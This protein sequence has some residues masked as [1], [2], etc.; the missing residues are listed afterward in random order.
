M[1][2]LTTVNFVDDAC[3]VTLS[4]YPHRASLK[5]LPGH[6][7]NCLFRVVFVF[8]EILFEIDFFCMK[9]C[10]VNKI[11]HFPKRK[12]ILWILR[13][14]WFDFLCILSFKGD[15]IQGNLEALTCSVRSGV[16]LSTTILNVV[17]QAYHI[18]LG[19]SYSLIW[20]RFWRLISLQNLMVSK[21]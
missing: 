7:G 8:T 5:N 13:T 11:T 6:G 1:Y 14:N 20:L 21:F 4:V 10:M 9:D 2:H 18:S 16:C 19:F 3:D 12:S 15:V 17:C